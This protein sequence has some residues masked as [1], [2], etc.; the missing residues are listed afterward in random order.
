M[1]VMLMGF[2]S[3]IIIALVAY[4]ALHQ[5]GFSSQEVYSGDNVRLD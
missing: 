3:I 1:K 4:F 2:S 5:M